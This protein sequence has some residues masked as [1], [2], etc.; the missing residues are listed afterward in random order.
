MALPFLAKLR[1][2][3]KEKVDGESR[4]DPAKEK[5]KDECDAKNDEKDGKEPEVEEQLDIQLSCEDS[6][7][8]FVPLKSSSFIYSSDSSDSWYVN[9]SK[10]TVLLPSIVTIWLPQKLIVQYK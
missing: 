7:S 4:E 6:G 3:K 8:D 10:W 2:I 1:K 9:I 5:K